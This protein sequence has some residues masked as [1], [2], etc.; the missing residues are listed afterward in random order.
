[1][2]ADFVI[3]DSHD[4]GFSVPA[5][6]ANINFRFWGFGIQ[7]HTG[8]RYLSRQEIDCQILLKFQFIYVL[9]KDA[10]SF[11]LTNQGALRI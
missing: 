9:L 11:L 10:L 7:S 1:M 4:T 3:D 2:S 6:Q 5:R 8:R